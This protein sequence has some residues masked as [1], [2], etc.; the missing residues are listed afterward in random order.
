[1]RQVG[2]SLLQALI[3]LRG[4]VPSKKLLLLAVMQDDNS[5]YNG[6]VFIIFRRSFACYATRSGG[7]QENY[8]RTGNMLR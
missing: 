3:H 1:V 8:L 5:A 4:V 2:L 6:E 7:R